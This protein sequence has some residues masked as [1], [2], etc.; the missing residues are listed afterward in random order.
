ML[1]Q[2]MKLSLLL[3]ICLSCA[4]CKHLKEIPDIDPVDRC[5]LYRTEGGGLKLLCHVYDFAVI[6]GEVLT[7]SKLEPIPD[8]LT[9]F[10]TPQWEIIAKKRDEV[11]KW[12]ENVQCK[13]R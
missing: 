8:K 12:A 2:I 1:K 5:L 9:C 4:N 3:T 7:E 11:L 10:S 6:G 13:V